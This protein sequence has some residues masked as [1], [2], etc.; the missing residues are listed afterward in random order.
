MSLGLEY[1]ITLALLP[2]ELPPPLCSEYWMKCI[3]AVGRNKISEFSYPDTKHIYFERKM[4]T[5]F[6]LQKDKRR[7]NKLVNEG[8]WV[9]LLFVRLRSLE[10]LFASTSLD[11][12]A[13]NGFLRCLASSEDTYRISC[14]VSWSLKMFFFV[15]KY[16]TK[17]VSF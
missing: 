4:S 9:E 15:L 2:Y 3:I 7:K 17:D 14:I 10:G 5:G 12:Y 13:T 8:R 11:C 6:Y 16:K 1:A